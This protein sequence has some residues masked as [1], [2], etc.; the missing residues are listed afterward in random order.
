ML[1]KIIV[2][3]EES[4]NGC[5]LCADACHEGAIDIVDGKA[6]LMR[7]HFCDGLGD[8]LPACPMNAISFEMREAPGYD[9]QAV[10]EA[11][12]KKTEKTLQAAEGEAPNA[13]DNWPVQLFLVSRSSPV[14]HN[15]DLLIAADCTAYAYGNFHRDFVAGRTTVIGCPKQHEHDL[16]E[17][18]TQILKENEIF[19]E[20]DLTLFSNYDTLALKAGVRYPS[21]RFEFIKPRKSRLALDKAFHYV[22]YDILNYVNHL[23]FKTTFQ[24]IDYLYQCAVKLDENDYDAVIF[25]NQMASLWVLKY[26]NNTEK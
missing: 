5:G 13:L 25:E 14:F 20:M 12:R 22:A 23:S 24:R 15:C 18:L 21:V 26:K 3:D 17:K 11:K 9:E 19:G 2:I 8:C 1:R 6:K 4:C 10:L 16:S 7:E